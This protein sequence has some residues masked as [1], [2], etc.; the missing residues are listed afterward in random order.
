MSDAHKLRGVHHPAYNPQHTIPNDGF[1]GQAE[2]SSGPSSPL[3]QGQISESLD[4]SHIQS[5]AN[6]HLSPSR[7]KPHRP[8]IYFDLDTQIT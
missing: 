4:Q 7:Q 6:E 5:S 2:P 3:G 8:G 1:S